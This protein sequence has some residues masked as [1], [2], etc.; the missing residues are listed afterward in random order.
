MMARF[1]D[2]APEDW[3]EPAVKISLPASRFTASLAVFLSAVA[4]CQNDAI[5]GPVLDRIN[6]TG[7]IRVASDPEWPPYSWIDES[8]AWQGF[9]ASV[10]QEVARRLGVRIEFVA[11][12]WEELTAGNWGGAWDLSVG[13]MSP[14]EEREKVLAFP[15]IYYYAPTVLAV[16]K[17]DA[18]I[19]SPP[20]ATGKRVGA[21]KDSIFEKY[22][23]HEPIGRADDP[24]PTYR[25]NNPVV[26]T[27][28]TS[29]DA[30]DALIEG[31][32]IDAMVDDL[33]YFLFLI[34]EGA[35]IKVVGQ[36]LYYGPAAMAVEPGDP[37]LEAALARIVE[38]MQADGTLSALSNRW[39]GVD[40]TQKF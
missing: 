29:A 8:G 16:L 9:D 39:F 27:F 3:S 13:S 34:K 32:T 6:Q 36:P 31:K 28:E 25:I 21:L 24:P 30:L 18:T 15:A 40:L 23:R 20:D 11:P 38:E 12:K 5:A 33:M 10:A 22:I 37:E 35:P 7:V 4:I 26:V 1:L 2:A 19:Q 17:D 14:T